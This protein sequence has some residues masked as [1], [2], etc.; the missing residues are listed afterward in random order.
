MATE[1]TESL[2]CLGIDHHRSAIALRERMAVSDGDLPG[3]L[4]HLVSLQGINGAVVL[5][6][7]NRCEF[8]LSGQVAIDAVVQEVAHRQ[9]VKAEELRESSYWHSGEESWRHLFRVA[10]SLESMVVGEYQIMHQVKFA[11][12][13]SRLHRKTTSILNKAF[14]KALAVGKEVRNET[15]IGKYKLSIASIAVD[16]ARQI[17][18]DLKQVHL[19]VA[20][21]GEMAEL[22]LQHFVDQGV[23]RMTLV[24]RNRNRAEEL[25]NKL[26]HD[27]D[28]EVQIIHWNELSAHLHSHDIVLSSTSAP[29][30]IIKREDVRKAMSKR[31]D[32]LM[33]ID[34]AVPRDIEAETA[35]VDDA[36]LFN[37]DS[38]EAVV[39]RNRQLREDEVEDVVQLVEARLKDCL[40][41][42]DGAAVALRGDIFKLFDRIAGEEAQRLNKKIGEAHSEDVAYACSRITKKM[43]HLMLDWLRRH[44]DEEGAVDTLR[45]LLDLPYDSE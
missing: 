1:A 39:A 14:Q 24:N 20:G 41:E 30:P 6:T 5:S 12:E 33:L 13:Q 40:K 25:A 18:G 16:L 45:D 8:Y 26:L 11:Y 38:L 42:D 10:A 43:Q 27:S 34:L 44:A 32:P 4:D 31:R 3:L 21:A 36:Y 17:H 37:I 7:C 9:G 22:S 2:F 28:L 19:L 23:H 35:D 15:G 29:M